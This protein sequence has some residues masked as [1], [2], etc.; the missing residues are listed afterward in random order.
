MV[1]YKVELQGPL[2]LFFPENY[3]SLTSLQQPPWGQKKVATVERLKQ[4]WMYGLSAKK[5]NGRCREVAIVERWPLVDVQPYMQYLS[6]DNVKLHFV[7]KKFFRYKWLKK[8]KIIKPSPQIV[9]TVGYERWLL[10]RDSNC[11][12]ITGKILVFW[13]SGFLR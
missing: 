2:L 8:W 10:R 9:V 11:K 12:A 4:E 13:G 1:A 3:Y 7:P 6:Y 5:E